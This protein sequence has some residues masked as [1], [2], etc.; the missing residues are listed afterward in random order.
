MV[1]KTDETILNTDCITSSK[2]PERLV[3]DINAG[4]NL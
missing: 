3:I 1:I 4:D 2:Q